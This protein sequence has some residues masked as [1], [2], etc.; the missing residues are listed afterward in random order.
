MGQHRAPGGPTLGLK[1]VLRGWGGNREGIKK[2]DGEKSKRMGGGSKTYH[3]KGE[4]KGKRV[5]GVGKGD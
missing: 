3:R 4:L 5:V 1:S 2:I